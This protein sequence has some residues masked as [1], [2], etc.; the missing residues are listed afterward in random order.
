MFV[1]YLF[2]RHAG[3]EPSQHVPNGDAEPPYARFTTSRSIVILVLTADMIAW[4][5]RMASCAGMGA[6]ELNSIFDIKDRNLLRYERGCG[7]SAMGLL[8]GTEGDR[9]CADPRRAIHDHRSSNRYTYDGIAGLQKRAPP[10]LHAN[11]IAIYLFALSC[12][13]DVLRSNSECRDLSF[14]CLPS[15]E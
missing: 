7:S 5:S 3:S 12:K 14:G 10:H 13:A 4:H 8:S 11:I 9:A 15:Q 1:Q 2:F 6:S